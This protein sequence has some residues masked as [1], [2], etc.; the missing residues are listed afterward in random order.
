MYVTVLYVISSVY[1]AYH[2]Y[3][4]RDNKW[5]YF[6]DRIYNWLQVDF[7]EDDIEESRIP[8]KVMF[9]LAFYACLG[10]YAFISSS[11]IAIVASIV[12]NLWLTSKNK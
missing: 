7:F 4:N 1:H 2:L 11:V 10:T 5:L 8:V 12:I 3:D 9:A 6:V